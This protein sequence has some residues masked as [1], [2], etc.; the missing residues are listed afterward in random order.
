MRLLI[1]AECQQRANRTETLL[2]QATAQAA[3][4]WPTSIEQKQALRTSIHAQQEALQKRIIQNELLQQQIEKLQ[5]QINPQYA[6]LENEAE[7]L[8]AFYQAATYHTSQPDRPRLRKIPLKDLR[9][10]H[11]QQI[12]GLAKKLSQLQEER[13]N[14][15]I[16]QGIDPFSGTEAADTLLKLWKNRTPQDRCILTGSD[17]SH[18]KEEIVTEKAESL[19][20]L[21]LVTGAA[22]LATPSEQAAYLS[23]LARLT[24]LNQEIVAVQ[25]QATQ[26]NALLQPLI[27][28][29]QSL[30]SEKWLN[31]SIEAIGNCL[32]QI[33][34]NL[35]YRRQIRDY[36]SNPDYSSASLL[37]DKAQQPELQR[38]KSELE[39][40]IRLQLLLAETRE[41]LK[42]L[43]DF[44]TKLDLARSTAQNHLIAQ[45]PESSLSAP[46]TPLSEL[47]QLPSHEI[48]QQIETL[49]QIIQ[50]EEQMRETT[51]ALEQKIQV[52]KDNLQN[53]ETACTELKSA[54]EAAQIDLQE[55]TELERQKTEALEKLKT[56]QQL[57]A[58]N[59]QN[60]SELRKTLE[61]RQ[62]LQK[63]EQDA[64][65][66][67]D[68]LQAAKDAAD[69][70]APRRTPKQLLRAALQEIVEETNR[71]L[72]ETG[73]EMELSV[74]PEMDFQVSFERAQRRITEPAR[75]L[76]CGLATLVGMCLKMALARILQPNLKFLAFDEPSA[77]L[78]PLKKQAFSQFLKSLSRQALTGNQI[79]V[80]EHDLA[81]AQS[82]DRQIQLA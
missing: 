60:E 20:A 78:D 22:A 34:R 52:L 79:L 57:H 76:G 11:Q 3:P 63:E 39:N 35:E 25:N 55:P 54:L 64:E 30:P 9:T 12:S 32:L 27:E 56:I 15:T 61:A 43:N 41:E 1:L 66:E 49:D 33:K 7:S 40:G 6:P 5:G 62:R 65:T 53:T 68:N 13:H 51:A 19:R 73:L 4:P 37:T 80:I 14:L 18:L 8:E 77:Q 69:F 38:Q 50:S 75:R 82:C 29:L 10:R 47:L 28:T 67:K 45:S 59:T 46:S 36:E 74:S 72:P 31:I 44:N 26:Q 16:E 81:I 24:G 17:L 23:H 48:R 42:K 2:Q 70:F 58:V 21:P 71:I